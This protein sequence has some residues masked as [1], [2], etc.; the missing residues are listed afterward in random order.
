M[1]VSILGS[2]RVGEALARGFAG[3]GHTVRIGSRTPE[4]VDPALLQDID[5]KHAFDY[6]GAIEPAEVVVLAVPGHAVV[7]LA[8]DLAEA[9][10]EKVVVD[11]TNEYPDPGEEI[12]LAQRVAR[13]APDAAVVKAFNTIG[14]EH[15]ADPDI[16][17]ERPS[18]F[19]AGDDDHALVTVSKLAADLGFDPVVTGH[20]ATA[21]RLEELGRLW[22]DLAGRDGRNIGFKLLRE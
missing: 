22:I 17:G 4:T 19:I 10:A 13:V 3:G 20:L 7:K 2:G 5:A 6:Y 14:A 21:R 18:M 9:L 15:M 8:N 1:N 11:P 16:G 12:P